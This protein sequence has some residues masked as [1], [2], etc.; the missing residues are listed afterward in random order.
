M[1]ISYIYILFRHSLIVTNDTIIF[2]SEM[3]NRNILLIGSNRRG[4]FTTFSVNW[5][6][7]ACI[8]VPRT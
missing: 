1:I 5:I 7:V 3:K 4:M 8:S 2:E 6:L